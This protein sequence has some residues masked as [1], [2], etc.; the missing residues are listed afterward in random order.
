MTAITSEHLIA[1]GHLQALGLKW[2]RWFSGFELFAKGK[3][4]A[5]NTSDTTIK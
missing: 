3:G 5:R 1:F 2:K 4:L